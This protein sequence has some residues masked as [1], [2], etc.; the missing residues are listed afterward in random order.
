[1]TAENEHDYPNPDPPD[2]PLPEIPMQQLPAFVFWSVVFT[3]GIG[4]LVWMVNQ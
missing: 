3:I 2:E 1:M 4:I